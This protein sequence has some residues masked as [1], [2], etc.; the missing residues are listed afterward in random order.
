M[1]KY[2][3]FAKYMDLTTLGLLGLFISAFLAGT[4]VPFS[5]EVVLSALILNGYDMYTAIIVATIGNFIGGQ[6][7]YYTGYIG[8][9]SW[10]EKYFRIRKE[11]II[12]AQKRFEKW[13][14]ISASL[15]FIPGLGNAI[16]LG[17]GFLKIKPKTCALY[18][19]LGKVA[20]YII[21]AYITLLV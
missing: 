1:S 14:P 17:L 7:T 2:N 21:W 20:R 12:N 15:S 13:G 3:I 11:K 5:S 16:V 19:L 6:T 10:V 9:W 4:I 18:M 8:K